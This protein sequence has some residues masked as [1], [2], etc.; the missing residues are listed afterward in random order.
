MKP[1]GTGK[2]SSVRVITRSGSK[3]SVCLEESTPANAYEN[4]SFLKN[5]GT[6][7]GC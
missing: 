1:G 5:T 4:R 3:A 6:E 2:K 7:S